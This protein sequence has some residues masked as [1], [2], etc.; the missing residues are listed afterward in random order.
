MNEKTNRPASVFANRMWWLF[1]SV[2]IVALALDLGT[3]AWALSHLE[4]GEKQNFIGSFITLQLVH[5][6]GAAFSLGTSSTWIF[7]IL[8]AAILVG[9]I[10]YALRNR[11]SALAVLL[12]VIAGGAAGNLYDRLTRPPGFGVG[13]V[14]DFINYNDWFVGN[15]ADIWIVVGAIVLVGWKLFTPDEGAADK[16]EAST[17]RHG[18]DDE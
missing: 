16:D 1:L 14:V 6:P 10:W 5:N 11:S 13:H 17:S 2:A 15:V 8:S 4:E 7:T 3:K 12:G 9:I 18:G